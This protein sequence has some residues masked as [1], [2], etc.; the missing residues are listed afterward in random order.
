MIKKHHNNQRFNLSTGFA[1]M[2]VILLC[3]VSAIYELLSMKKVHPVET[4]NKHKTENAKFIMMMSA[5]SVVYIVFSTPLLVSTV[6]TNYPGPR[7][8]ELTNNQKIKKKKGI[9]NLA[10]FLNENENLSMYV[11]E[12]WIYRSCE[13]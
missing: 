10:Y 4:S 7:L 8:N 2:M 1:C 6:I 12:L 9:Y 11:F 13:F 5:I 3:N